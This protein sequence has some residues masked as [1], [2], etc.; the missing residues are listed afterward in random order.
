MQSFPNIDQPERLYDL[1]VSVRAEQI[2][3]M[4]YPDLIKATSGVRASAVAMAAHALELAAPMAWLREV[5]L[6]RVSKEFI[7]LEG[8]VTFSSIALSVALQHSPKV[9]LFVVTLG[10]R[11][12]E[13][14]TELFQAMDGVEGLFLD[15]AGWILVQSALSAVRRHLGSVADA[16]NYRVTRRFG[17][18]YS[19]WPLEEAATIVTTLAAG[20][21]LSGIEVL[22]S[23]S[24]L[25]EKTLTGLYGLVP[26]VVPIQE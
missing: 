26:L 2:L 9:V 6:R 20:R 17:P 14:V 8:G 24:I 15:T 16:G 11:L 23:G 1:P 18:G 25:P 7:E 5:P 21:E 10:S 13:R 3:R 12:D 4:H 19:D 22:E